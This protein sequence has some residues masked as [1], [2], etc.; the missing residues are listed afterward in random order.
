FGGKVT[1]YDATEALKVKGVKKVVQISSGVAVLATNTWSAMQGR[2]KLKVQY[3]DGKWANLSSEQIF[4]EHEKMASAPG[5]VAKNTGN[6]EAV[7]KR[8]DVKVVSAT[9]RGPYLAH[10]AMEPVNATAWVHDGI[11]EVWGPIQT[12]TAAQ[13]VASKIAGVPLDKVRVTTMF[14]GGAFGRKN[15]TDP[16]EDAVE[17]SM[18]AGVP[19]K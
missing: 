19:V 1:S 5:A 16:V 3:D 17:A 4:A 7:L 11:V 14:L 13:T 15:E 2:F 9:Y 8:P 12:Q 6:V 10:A 18:K